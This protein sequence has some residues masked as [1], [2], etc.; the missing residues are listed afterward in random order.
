MHLYFLPK[1]KFSKLASPNNL[2]KVFNWVKEWSPSSLT[3][4]EAVE[5]SFIAK[6]LQQ[7][8][9]K[10][11]HEKFGLSILIYREGHCQ[12]MDYKIYS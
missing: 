10:I 5:V 8:K 1:C 4:E 7:L 9:K 3:Q 2:G 6:N 11:F 12:S